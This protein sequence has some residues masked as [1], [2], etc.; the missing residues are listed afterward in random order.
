MI[1]LGLHRS[2]MRRK[3][4]VQMRNPTFCPAEITGSFHTASVL[5]RAVTTTGY[6]IAA[7]PH[8]CC[9][10]PNHLAPL[11]RRLSR[12]YPVP[13]GTTHD[14]RYTEPLESANPTIASVS[15]YALTMPEAG[16]QRCVEVFPSNNERSTGRVGSKIPLIA[17]VVDSQQIEWHPSQV[18]RS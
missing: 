6:W 17:S 11:S 18:C 4:S 7:P 3:N 13:R 15:S 8:W 5:G 1:T 10:R 9:S 2:G 14:V 12:S 16:W